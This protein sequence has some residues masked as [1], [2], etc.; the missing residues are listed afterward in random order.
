MQRLPKCQQVLQTAS[1]H[2]LHQSLSRD[3]THSLRHY[4]FDTELSPTPGCGLMTYTEAIEE[5]HAML[6]GCLGR[7][8]FRLR[9]VP[10]LV[11]RLLP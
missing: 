2:A 3:D 9:P 1:S 10:M 8:L 7:V 4:I 11:F 6:V 5:V